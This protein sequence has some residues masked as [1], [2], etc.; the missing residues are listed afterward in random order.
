MNTDEK[1]PKWAEKY[2]NDFSARME[3]LENPTQEPPD[4]AKEAEDEFI[5]TMAEINDTSQID[6]W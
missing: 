4:P 2:L 3:K 1:I 6:R 5:K